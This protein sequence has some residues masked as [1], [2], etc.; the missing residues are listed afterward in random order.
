M[1]TKKNSKDLVSRETIQLFTLVSVADTNVVVPIEG[2]KL[3]PPFFF[4]CV[5][6]NGAVGVLG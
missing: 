3:P 2:K 6:E 5:W 1:R 4:F